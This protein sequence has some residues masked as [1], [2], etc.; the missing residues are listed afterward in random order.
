MLSAQGSSVIVLVLVCVCVST[1]FHVLVVYVIEVCIVTMK[2]KC[3]GKHGKADLNIT[4][5]PRVRANS[6]AD[7]TDSEHG[8]SLAHIAQQPSAVP[9]FSDSVRD[10]RET[11]LTPPFSLTQVTHQTITIETALTK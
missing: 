3:V 6:R 4:C 10:Y 2:P 5:S 7:K 8:H 1:G 9:S 11:L